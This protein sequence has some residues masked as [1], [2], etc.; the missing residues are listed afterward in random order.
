MA[1]WLFDSQGHPIVFVKDDKVFSGNGRFIGRLDDDEVW[2]GR[3]KGEIVKGD[4]FLY[5][6]SKGSVIRGTPGTPGIPGIPGRPGSK[7]TIS[8]PSG[9]RD[10]I[11]EE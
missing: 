3:Y 10:V 4:R 7:S 5:K 8:V 2:H 9:Y 6:T 11:L 1:T